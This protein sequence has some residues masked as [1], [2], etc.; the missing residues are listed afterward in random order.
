MSRC[1]LT[2]EAPVTR[3]TDVSN[4]KFLLERDASSRSEDGLLSEMYQ[5]RADTILRGI[6]AFKPYSLGEQ[7]E[8]EDDSL[9][10]VS[11]V[12]VQELWRQA[13]LIHFYQS[14]Y[15]SPAT[16]EPLQKCMRQI[17]KLMEVLA[18]AAPLRPA[19]ILCLPVFLAASVAVEKDARETLIGH[20]SGFDTVLG[21]K[22]NK[23]L[24]QLIW[25]ESDRLGAQVDW[26]DYASPTRGPAF[27]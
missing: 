19:A 26:R 6:R 2:V 23:D 18:I 22:Q 16:F 5:K 27:L 13:T 25:S 24:V 7:E 21:F 12:T 20:L 17:I 3:L 11:G 15:R 4:L 1:K 10:H 8:H 14:I 9:A